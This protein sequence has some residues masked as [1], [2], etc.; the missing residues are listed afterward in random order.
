VA[1]K[2]GETYLPK[3]AVH[4]VTTNHKWIRYQVK[5]LDEHKILWLTNSQGMSP[6]TLKQEGN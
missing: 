5:D 3:L 4:T 6:G 2:K 1:H